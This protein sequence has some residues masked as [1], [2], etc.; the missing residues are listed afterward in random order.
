[1]TKLATAKIKYKITRKNNPSHHKFHTM[2]CT[3]DDTLRA[4]KDRFDDI[5]RGNKRDDV[6]FEFCSAEIMY[7]VIN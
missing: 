5:V 6:E 2:S 4:I 7:D 1:M 3:E